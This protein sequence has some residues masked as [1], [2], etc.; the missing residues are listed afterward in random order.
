MR[1]YLVIAILI[2]AFATPALAK[3]QFYVAFDPAVHKCSMMQSEP[4]G[5]MKNLGGPYAT[6]DEARKAMADMKE[7]K[8]L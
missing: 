8:G 3:E 2:A 1:E 7:C 5:S 6:V 4:T